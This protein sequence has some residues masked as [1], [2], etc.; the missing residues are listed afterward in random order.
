MGHRLRVSGRLWRALTGHNRAVPFFY[1]YFMNWN[2]LY[3][4][5]IEYENYSIYGYSRIIVDDWHKVMTELDS[6]VKEST[7]G[8]IGS[9]SER[10]NW[11]VEDNFI[12]YVDEFKYLDETM[13]SCEAIELVV[14]NEIEQSSYQ[15]GTPYQ[16]RRH[17][18]FV[19]WAM[20]D[21]YSEEKS[22]FKIYCEG[23]LPQF[24]SKWHRYLME[25][26]CVYPQ[27][28]KDN[29]KT[30]LGPKVYPED[31]ELLGKLSLFLNVDEQKFPE[32][33]NG[34]FYL[35]DDYNKKHC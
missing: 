29:S 24:I 34:F 3:G 4:A 10:I 25:S 21:V 32:A 26:C 31:Y 18:Q 11:E 19:Q 14:K 30:L 6:F 15:P 1:R 2:D 23:P 33:L 5:Y 28:L 9:F 8:L 22:Y 20:E 7:E 12:D 17:W 13:N 16:S 35:V 27:I